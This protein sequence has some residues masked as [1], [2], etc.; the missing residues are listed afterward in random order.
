VTR[1]A[2][3][4]LLFVTIVASHAGAAGPEFVEPSD[5]ARRPDL[6]GR[7]VVVD[8]RIRYF[9]ESR[10]GQGFDELLLKRTDVVFRLPARLRYPR[11]PSEF[12]ARVRGV[13]KVEE[14]RWSCDVSAI[15]LLPNDMDRLEREVARLRPEDVPGRR[16]WALW[17]QRRGKELGE[18]KLEARGVALEAEALWTEAAR[19]EADPLGLAE[20]SVG[21]PIPDSVRNALAHRGL[22]DGLAKAST[23]AEYDTLAAKVAAVLPASA[24]PKAA[25]GVD[26]ATRAAYETDPAGAYREAAEPARA[27]L[28]RRLL[29]DAIQKSFEK[30]A[31]ANPGDAAALAESAAA[32]LPD[33]PDFA[34]R[35][36]QRGLSEAEAH[37]ASMRQAEVEDLARKF[38]D[39]G[40]DDRARRL[41]QSWLADRRKNRLSA[42]DAEGRVL[43]A[44]SFDKLLGD[45]AVA[46]DLLREALAI[47]PQSRPAVDALLRMGFRKGDAGWYDPDAARTEPAPPADPA[48]NPARPAA[49]AEAG[50]SLRGLTRAQVRSRLGGKPDLVVRSATQGRCVE[51]W[52]YRNGKGTQV[53][54]FPIEP[55]TGEPRAS[56]FYSDPK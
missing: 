5:L 11:P 2:G 22:R 41:L 49:P 40:Q 50:D 21:R 43:L 18:P 13:L 9:L 30:Q 55:G 28:D 8:D 33:R 19:P 17:A 54:N 27:A 39:R 45:R 48:R 3:L 14:G 4:V 46:A 42:T 35:L 32:R 15:E 24:D 47:D 37:V 29:A 34:D 12:N 16:G 23:P 53:V 31:E 36:R 7:D 10:R 6:A 26:A 38:R 20:R 56:S 25:A 51:Q 52:I 44:A 1:P